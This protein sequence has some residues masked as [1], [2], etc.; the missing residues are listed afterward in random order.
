MSS[1]KMYFEFYFLLKLRNFAQYVVDVANLFWRNSR[2]PRF[3]HQ[4][5]QQE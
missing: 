2:K 5:K 1:P 3:P 4:V